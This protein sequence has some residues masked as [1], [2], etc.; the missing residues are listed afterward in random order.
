M[1]KIIQILFAAVVLTGSTAALAKWQPVAPADFSRIKPAD[2]ADDELDLPYHLQHFHKVA[3]AVVEEGAD[4]GFFNTGLWRGEGQKHTYNARIME[5][6][7]TLAYFYCTDRAWNPYFRSQAVRE[8]LE[9]ALEYL[10]NMQ[11]DDGRF[12]EYG[13]KEWNLPAT[14]FATKFLGETL[15]LLKSGPPIDP[16]LHRRVI[17]AD[18]KA[19]VVTLTM[20]SLYDHG[21]RY[22]NQYCN[23]FAGGMAYIDLY[24]DEQI[25]R[26]VSERFKDAMRDFQS[27]AGFYYER[28]SADF[29][30]VFHTTRSDMNMAYHYARGTDLGGWIEEMESRWAEWISYNLVRQPDGSGYVINRGV[31]SR[32]RHAFRDYLD[33]GMAEKVPGSRAFSTSVAELRRQRQEAR[34]ALERDW[35]SYNNPSAPAKQGLSPYAFLHRA[36]YLWHPSAAQKQEAIERLPYLAR[37]S[38]AHQRSDSRAKLTCTYV[39]RAGFYAAFNSGEPKHEQQRLGLGIVWSPSAGAVLQS[40]T[41]SSDHAWGTRR[42]GAEQVYEAGKVTASYEVD[43][44]EIAP[45]D[46]AR[47]LPPGRLVVRYPLGESGKK[48]VTFDESGITVEIE[49]RG[50]FVEQIPLL[51]TGAAVRIDAPAAAEMDPLPGPVAFGSTRVTSHRI[52]GEGRLRY[53]IAL[54]PQK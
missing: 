7:L 48:E 1:T 44:K 29:G 5:S 23:V 51:G 12:S 45:Q 27:P 14:A 31:E 4:R 9:A 49:H 6:H 40:Q 36:H 15:R 25:R 38:F 47:D 33:T 28:D 19:I 42:D 10:V 24:P 20:P 43:G 54:M 13:V 8:R 39:R 26:L 35:A 2:F 11:N 30:Y 16:A 22:T 53:V 52:G 17:E 18:R 50:R 21:R 3:N 37:S 34:A 32:Q 46:G 41:A